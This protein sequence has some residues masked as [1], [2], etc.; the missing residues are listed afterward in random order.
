LHSWSATP[1]TCPPI[2][3]QAC[4][5]LR[6]TGVCD[7]RTWKALIGRQEAQPEDLHLLL[8]RLQVR[9]WWLLHAQPWGFSWGRGQLLQ[10]SA[11]G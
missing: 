8:A 5:D 4:S 11:E 7:E 3:A 2:R 1:F 6:E 9:C 10:P